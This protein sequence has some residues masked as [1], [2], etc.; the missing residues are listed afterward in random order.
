MADLALPR[1]ARPQPNFVA[2][3][4]DE[5]SDKDGDKDPARNARKTREF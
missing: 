1:W 5:A 4:V 3:F 2:N